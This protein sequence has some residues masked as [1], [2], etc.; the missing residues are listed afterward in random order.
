MLCLACANLSK[1]NAALTLKGFR[2]GT[3]ILK[4]IYIRNCTCSFISMK[5][6]SNEGHGF[7]SMVR[8]FVLLQPNVFNTELIN[9]EYLNTQDSF[10]LCYRY[11]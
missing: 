6:K 4:M 8:N 5:H 9:F 1:L 2:L 3:S 7:P 10:S 11:G